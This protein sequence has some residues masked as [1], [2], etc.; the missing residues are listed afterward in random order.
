MT[1]KLYALT[2]HGCAAESADNPMFQEA[3]VA[4]HLYLMVLKDRLKT[5]LQSLK[6]VIL[7]KVSMGKGVDMLTNPSQ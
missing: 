3:L 4:G 5:W 7:K 1:Q 6:S 2:K